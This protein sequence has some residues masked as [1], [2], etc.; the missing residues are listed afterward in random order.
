MLM[1][2][3]GDFQILQMMVAETDNWGL[4][5]EIPCYH[6]I[7]NNISTLANK[8]KAYQWDID[9]AW[10]NLMGCES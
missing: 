6:E 10:A 5:R 2:P 3:G 1:G 9:A 4:A 7:D 8:L